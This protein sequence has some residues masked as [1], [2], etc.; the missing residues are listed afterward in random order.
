MRRSTVRSRAA[1]GRR[2]PGS[3]GPPD[4]GRARRD[5]TERV[6]K[7]PTPT[8][9][10]DRRPQAE[11]A[12]PDSYPTGAPVWVHRGGRWRP[13]RVLGS[14][15]LAVMV[16]YRP[17]DNHGTAVDTV[18]PVSLLTRTDADP[19]DHPATGHLETAM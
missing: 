4:P 1:R 12:T 10:P 18:R 9:D 17:T 16:R 2:P 19:V 6:V 7:V 11:I 15:P 3:A 14:S 13:S 8:L 5:R